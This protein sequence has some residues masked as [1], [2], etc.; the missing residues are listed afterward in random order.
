MLT[1]DPGDSAF[2][3][4][5]VVLERQARCT[6][7]CNA[8]QK[9]VSGTH[10]SAKYGKSAVRVQRG[11]QLFQLS[12]RQLGLEGWVRFGQEGTGMRGFEGA[13]ASVGATAECWETRGRV[14]ELFGP[15]EEE[16]L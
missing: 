16:S 10:I 12:F 2:S 5:T 14:R 6:P 11:E 4:L 3:A 13:E 1:R 7:T 9:A 8:S 15:S